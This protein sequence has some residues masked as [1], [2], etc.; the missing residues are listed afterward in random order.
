M[1]GPPPLL[2]ACGEGGHD[3]LTNLRQ[4]QS[5]TFTMDTGNSDPFN[6]ALV[7]DIAGRV[8][9][10]VIELLTRLASES[11]RSVVILSAA[12]LDASLETLLKAV[13]HPSPGGTD[14]LFAPERPM[15]SLSAKISLAYR[16]GLV[17]RDVE[18]VL[19]MIRRI[20]N[21][22]AHSFG[23]ESLASHKQVQRITEA[24]R[25]VRQ[26]ALWSLTQQALVALRSSP[27]IRDFHRSDGV[28]HYQARDIC[29]PVRQTNNGHRDLWI[30]SSE[31]EIGIRSTNLRQ[32]Q[33]RSNRAWSRRLIPSTKKGKSA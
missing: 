19:Q 4:R 27:A 14:D 2:R 7:D 13:M 29:P 33:L 5:E 31:G 3:G 12:R 6:Q 8:T 26:Y 24:V 28:D 10:A 15:G 20:R 11:E 23:E 16:L 9:P 25:T 30:Q 17:D 32:R 21:D 22:F 18:H 1:L